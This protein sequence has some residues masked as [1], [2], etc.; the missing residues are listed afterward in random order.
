MTQTLV[1]KIAVVLACSIGTI[2]AISGPVYASGVAFGLKASSQGLGVELTGSL[3][4]RLN[5]RAGA[6]YFKFGQKLSKGGNEYDF[7]LKLKSFSALADW[8]VF[9]GAFRIT[10]GAVLDKNN[11]DGDAITSNGFNIGDMVFTS[12]EVGILTGNVHFREVSPYLGIGWGNPVAKDSGWT[13]MVDLGV[14][15]AGTAKVDLSSV[16]GTLSDQPLFLTELRKE[17]DNVRGELNN[18]KYYPVISLG[19][20]RKF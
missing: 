11:L 4:E 15:F 19:L 14:M 9:G 5:I 3:A 10:G 7:D 18:F 17:E 16:G 12:E 6:H 8:H 2:A 13:F 1:K 20:S